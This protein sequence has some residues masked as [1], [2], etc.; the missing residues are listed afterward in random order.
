MVKNTKHGSK[1]GWEQGLPAIEATRFLKD[2]IASIAGKPCSHKIPSPQIRCLALA[3]FQL[4]APDRSGR[5][6]RHR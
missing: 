6:R 3:L 1:T 5:T 4:T 2:R